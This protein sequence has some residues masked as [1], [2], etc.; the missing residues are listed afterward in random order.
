MNDGFKTS[1]YVDPQTWLVMRRRDVRPLHIDVDPTPTII[2]QRFSDYREVSGVRY[3]FVDTETDLKTGKL[4]E[5]SRT[6]GIKV[7]PPIDEAIFSK[8]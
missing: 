2:E 6:T 1:L 4:L 7:N 8:L 5:S 3:A